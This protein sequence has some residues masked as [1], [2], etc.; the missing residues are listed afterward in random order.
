MAGL[1]RV[2]TDEVSGRR[3]IR[4]VDKTELTG[5]GS[6]AP[7]ERQCGRGSDAALDVDVELNLGQRSQ[8]IVGRQHHRSSLLYRGDG[9]THNSTLVAVRISAPGSPPRHRVIDTMSR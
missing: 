2:N 9:T 4:S 3:T 5:I 8:V 6:M 7:S 1:P